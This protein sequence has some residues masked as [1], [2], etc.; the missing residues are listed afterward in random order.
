MDT[1]EKSVLR[2]GICGAGM[3]C[4]DFCSALLS[5]KEQDRK[6]KVPVSTVKSEI[7]V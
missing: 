2:W 1:M 5:P 7:I 6:H 3:I 4:N